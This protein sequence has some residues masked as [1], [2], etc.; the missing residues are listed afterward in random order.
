LFLLQRWSDIGLIKKSEK[1]VRRKYEAIWE[2]VISQ[3]QAKHQELDSYE[4]WLVNDGVNIGLG[5]KCWESKPRKPKW[6]LS[7]FWI[8]EI[9]IED[10]TSEDE[11]A[12]DNTIWINH[13][14]RAVDIE[15]AKARLSEAA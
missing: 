13:P 2:K 15:E 7:G 9:R 11:D 1:G 6:F 10:L 12:A 4:I 3:V 5:R 14:Q 8:G